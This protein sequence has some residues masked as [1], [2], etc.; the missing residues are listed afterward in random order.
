MHLLDQ[1][2]EL[3]DDIR[4]NRR[5]LDSLAPIVYKHHL[6]ATLAQQNQTDSIEYKQLQYDL[7]PTPW[8]E[9][10]RCIAGHE[11]R[12]T[13]LRQMLSVRVCEVR[14]FYEFRFCIHSF[15]SELS[16]DPNC[17]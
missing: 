1:I 4:F 10:E 17:D 3:F 13:Y 9:L 8:C 11:Q 2:K 14:T 5:M 12:I 15:G 7:I 16:Y 6:K